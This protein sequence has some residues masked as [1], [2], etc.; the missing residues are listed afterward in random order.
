MLGLRVTVV[1]SPM[2][3]DSYQSSA[4][5]VWDSKQLKDCVLGFRVRGTQAHVR[6]STLESYG[7]SRLP[8]AAV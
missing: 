2:S 6:F 1:G 5:E 7:T 4:A 3:S 8:A